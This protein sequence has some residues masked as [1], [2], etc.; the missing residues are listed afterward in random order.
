ML[1]DFHAEAQARFAADTTTLVAVQTPDTLKAEAIG[2]LL[3]DGQQTHQFLRRGVCHEL[4]PI[5]RPF[6]HS[7]Q[8]AVLGTAA[9]SYLIVRLPATGVSRTLLQAFVVGETNNLIHNT[10]GGCS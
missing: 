5:A 7:L 9:L 4:D 2:E 1:Y 10:Q 3:I 6:V 8:G